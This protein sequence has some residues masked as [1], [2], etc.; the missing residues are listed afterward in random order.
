MKR[1][2]LDLFFPPKCAFCGK[3][4]VHGVCAA[5]VKTLPY[6]EK[7]LREGA[8]FGRCAAPLLYEGVVCESIL[9]FKFH[10][11]QSAAEG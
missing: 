2:L 10:G 9:R 11:A 1:A 8:G 5:C 3:I 7:P 4:G 6:A